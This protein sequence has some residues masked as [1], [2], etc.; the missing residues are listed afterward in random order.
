MG[1]VVSEV[2][3][4]LLKTIQDCCSIHTGNTYIIYKACVLIL[5]ISNWFYFPAQLTCPSRSAPCCCPRPSPGASPLCR[6]WG[7]A[8]NRSRLVQPSQP[9]VFVLALHKSKHIECVRKNRTALRI[10][11][12]AVIF[13]SAALRSGKQQEE[14]CV[15]ARWTSKYGSMLSELLVMEVWH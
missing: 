14:T 3:I 2:V 5:N 6:S 7:P 13:H 11:R 12:L 9:M 10:N 15:R 4:F 1:K 8:N